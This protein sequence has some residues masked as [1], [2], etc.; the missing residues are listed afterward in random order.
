[1]RVRSGRSETQMKTWNVARTAGVAVF[2]ALLA[3]ACG[4]GGGGDSA[5]SGAISI[6]LTDA[7]V[8]SAMEVVVVFTGVELHRTNGETVSIDFGTNRAIDLMKLQGG[9]TS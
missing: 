5:G 6:N 7:P 9:V 2:G 3:T 4:G 1:M 8:D